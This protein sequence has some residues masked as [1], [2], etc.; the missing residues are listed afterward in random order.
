MIRYFLMLGTTGFGGPV[1][2]CEHMR[3]NLVEERSWISPE[4]YSEGFS[5]SQL[6]PGP[7][8]TQLAIYLGW[9]RHG[10]LG[11]TAAGIAFVLPSFLMVL[12]LS[13]CYVAFDGLPWI[14]GAFYGIGSAVIAIM[15]LSSYKLAA[16]TFKSDWL[17][18]GIGLAS[19]LLTVI[20]GSEWFLFFLAGGALVAI[21]RNFPKQ[22]TIASLVVFPPFLLSG[23]HG[24]GSKHLLAMIFLYFAKAGAMVFGS[25]LAIVPFLHG[26]VVLNHHWL[27]ERQFLDSVAVAMITPGPVV[28]TVAFIGFLVSGA[29][30]AVAAGL[31]VFLPCYLFVIIPAPFYSRFSKNK[32]MRAFVDG[33]TSAAVGA[34]AGATIVLG[35]RALTDWLAVIF[36][37]VPLIVLWRIKR[38]PEPVVIVVA[39][40]IGILA[41]HV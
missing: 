35:R 27:T 25:G 18:W 32:T 28:I 10:I 39:G 6:A 26:G 34:I 16:K 37:I 40:V 17:L 2:L 23:I 13:F 33:V 4:E 19:A 14:Q 38:V 21:A 1:V 29:L 5:L 11:A 20:T 22:G 9:V 41:K 24:I 30:G 8:A 3:R 12:A 7:L 31:G 15:V 36:F